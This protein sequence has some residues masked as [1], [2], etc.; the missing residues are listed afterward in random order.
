MREED[1]FDRL[2][3]ELELGDVEVD[4]DYEPD[5]DEKAC[6]K[7]FFC[8]ACGVELDECNAPLDGEY[9][10]ACLADRTDGEC[11]HSCL[12][13]DTLLYDGYS[14]DDDDNDNF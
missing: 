13:D 12:S 3:E 14:D 1:E 5:E 8:I 2:V 4:E 7:E 11:C 9:C 10:H 6:F